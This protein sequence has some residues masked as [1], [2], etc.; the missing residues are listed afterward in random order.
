[1]DNGDGIC[2]GCEPEQEGQRHTMAVSN[3]VSTSAVTIDFRKDQARID[4]ESQE[5]SVVGDQVDG[6]IRFTI[7]PTGVIDTMIAIP[8]RSQH[9]KSYAYVSITLTAGDARILAASLRELSR[10]ANDSEF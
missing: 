8:D 10:F 1:M 7:G 4:V 3:G 6:G 2:L 5:R 9:S